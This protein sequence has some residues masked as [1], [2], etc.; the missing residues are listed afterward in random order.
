MTDKLRGGRLSSQVTF[1]FAAVVPAILIISLLFAVRIAILDY[2]AMLGLLII[3][4]PAG[5]CL[6]LI[7]FLISL[8]MVRVENESIIVSSFWR[9]DTVA[10]NRMF[11]VE[12][13]KARAARF[14]RVGHVDERGKKRSFWFLADMSV[15]YPNDVHPAVTY[16]RSQISA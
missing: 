5:A 4:I 9:S 8:R 11:Q 2:G 12:E 15:L 6:G 16:L 7:S 13:W 14:V 1:I 10:L 3:A